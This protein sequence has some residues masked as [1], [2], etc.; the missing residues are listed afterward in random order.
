MHDIYAETHVFP[1]HCVLS[2]T[3]DTISVM[4]LTAT[5]TSYER[6]AYKGLSLTIYL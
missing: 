6:K 2:L 5:Y 1:L 4:H 3:P